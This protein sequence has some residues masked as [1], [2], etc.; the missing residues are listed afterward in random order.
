MN[1][2]KLIRVA[3]SYGIVNINIGRGIGSKADL[4]TEILDVKKELEKI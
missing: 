2:E 3:N 4:I 1:Y